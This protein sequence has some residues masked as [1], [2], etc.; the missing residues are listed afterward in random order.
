MTYQAIGTAT[1]FPGY[2]VQQIKTQIRITEDADNGQSAARLPMPPRDF[3]RS[4]R[5]LNSNI[6]DKD[7]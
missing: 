5:K 3:I 6:T 2:N 4:F 7:L 1:D